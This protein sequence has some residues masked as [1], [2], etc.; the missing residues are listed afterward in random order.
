MAQRRKEFLSIRGLS[1]LLFISIGAVS[2]P[3]NGAGDAPV[4]RDQA[5]PSGVGEIEDTIGSDK[6][7]RNSAAKVENS[8]IEDVEVDESAK[9]TGD[10]QMNK[11]AQ[12]LLN[13]ITLKG[14]TVMKEEDIVSLVQPYIGAM[15][16][17][18]DLQTIASLLTQLFNDRGYVT[19]KCTIPA[20]QVKDGVVLLQV[21][22]DKLN[23][24]KLSGADSYRYDPRLFL[25]QLHDLQGKVIHLP[26][27]NSR[28]RLLSQLPSTRVQPVLVKKAEGRTDLVLNLSDLKSG[29]AISL[30]NSGSRYTGTNRLTAAATFNNLTGSS[31]VLSISFKTSLKNSKQLGAVTLDYKYPVG[32]SGGKIGLGYSDLYYR[33]DPNEVGFDQVRYEGG[34]QSLSFRYHQPFWFGVSEES[35]SNYMWS[36]GIERK[37]AQAKTVY[38]TSFDQP[39]GFAYVDTQDTLMVGDF[40][41]QAERLTLISGYKGRYIGSI[42]LKHAL[43]GFFGATT[44][45]DIDRKLENIESEEVDSITG[46]IGNVKGLDPNFWK[47]Y[48]DVSREQVLPNN[49]TA[50]INLQGEFTNSKKVAQTYQ[51]TPADGGASGLVL[52]AALQRPIMDGLSAGI[53]FQHAKAFSWYRD[54]DPGCMDDSGNATAT[55]AGRNSCSTNQVEL[56]MNWN[57]GSLLARV[58]YRKNIYASDGNNKKI[59]FNLGY[60]W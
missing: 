43:E 34:A 33:M 47:L 16:T 55:S 48:I 7:N 49:F 58:N 32:S 59:T 1:F 57:L 8:V 19:S 41:L 2:L 22:E 12:F 37:S 27:L 14:N 5:A 56:N 50:K 13:G 40:T 45:E 44:Q 60:R 10:S 30:D 35:A 26:T 29:F 23:Q 20:Q 51:F 17:S 54:E 36:A 24:I 39:A 42:G 15:V 18:Y 3:V 46:P 38:N 31:D 52:T 53:S 21:V 6:P 25:K 9:P 11:G 4:Q 28:L